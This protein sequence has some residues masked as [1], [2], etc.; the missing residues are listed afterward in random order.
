MENLSHELM[1]YTIDSYKKDAQSAVKIQ[2][3]PGA[4][5]F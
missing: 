1:K 3:P 4:A 2:P 5:D